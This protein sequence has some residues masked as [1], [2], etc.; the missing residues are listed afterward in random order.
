MKWRGR[1]ERGGGRGKRGKAYHVGGRRLVAP[2]L[3][4]LCGEVYFFG[5]G[6]GGMRKRYS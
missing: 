4:C 1:E 5:G 6:G 3:I 2:L